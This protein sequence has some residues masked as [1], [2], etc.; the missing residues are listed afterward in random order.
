MYQSQV[1]R[2]AVLIFFFV[3]SLGYSDTVFYWPFDGTIGQELISTEDMFLGISLDKFTHPGTIADIR[4]G[5]PN[6]WFNTSGTSGEF[7]NDRFLNTESF[8]AGIV[9]QDL[10]VNTLLDLST[11]PSFT[12]EV[13]IYPYVVQKCTVLKKCGGDGQYSL[14]L[15]DEGDL[16]F[17]INRDQNAIYA[18]QQ[19]IKPYTWYHIAAVFD[20]HIQAPMKLFVNG[21]LV[22]WG[23]SSETLLDSTYALGVGTEVLQNSVPPTFH[24]TSMYFIGRIDDLR[25]SNLALSPSEFLIN[26]L[27]TKARYPH[28]ENEA[29]QFSSTTS[30]RWLPPEG[31]QH[32]KVYFGTTSELDSIH[33]LKEVGPEVR[34]ISHTE[35]NR[36]LLPGTTYYWRVDCEGDLDIHNNDSDTQYT[37]EQDGQGEVWKFTAQDST[38]QGYLKWLLHLGQTP[39]DRIEWV[40]P[41]DFGQFEERTGHVYAPEP[42]QIYDFQDLHTA[43]TKDMLIW[44]PEY[45]P[46]GFF[47]ENCLGEDYL[48]YYHIYIVSPDERQARFGLRSGSRLYVWNNRELLYNDGDSRHEAPLDFTLH[49]G[50][51]SITFILRGGDRWSTYLAAR[52][53][54]PNG[55]EYPDLSYSLSPPLP[56]QEIYVKRQLPYRYDPGATVSV[57]LNINVPLGTEPNE[58]RLFETIPKGFQVIDTGE[59]QVVDNTIQ[60]HLAGAEAKPRDIVYTLKVPYEYMNAIA[61]SGH[62]YWGRQ[63]TDI[64][65]SSRLFR[66]HPINP[67]DCAEDIETIEIDPGNYTGAENVAVEHMDEAPYFILTGLRADPN[68]GWASY[69]FTVETSSTYSIILDYA[70]YWTLFHHSVSISIEIDDAAPIEVDLYPTTHSYPNGYL[71]Q[72]RYSP[73]TDPHR[74]AKWEIGTIPLNAG[75]HTLRMTFPEFLLTEDKLDRTTDGRPVINRIILINYPGLTLPH[76]TDPHHLDSYEH[77]PA[78][79]VHSRD[80]RY[81]ADGRKEL[82]F[83]GTF[84]SLSQGDEIYASEIS[85]RPQPG[86][87][88]TLFETVSLEPDVFH[89]RS[90]GE[91]DFALTVR[92]KAPIPDDYSELVTLWLQGV[93]SSPSRRLYLFS[94][95]TEYLPLPPFSYY[96]DT[97]YPWLGQPIFGL[98]GESANYVKRD[99]SDSAEQF[100]P[101]KEDLGFNKGR[102]DRDIIRFF[103]DQFLTGDL[104]GIVQIFQDNFWDYDNHSWMNWSHFWSGVFTSLYKRDSPEQAKAYVKRLSDNL[105]FYPVTTRWDWTR[106]IKLPNV[107]CDMPGIA[108]LATHVRTV[109]EGI[110]NDQEQCY[111]LHNL[112]LPLFNSYIDSSRIWAVLADDVQPG[113]THIPILRSSYGPTGSPSDGFNILGYIMIGEDL[114]GLFCEW[115]PDGLRLNYPLE[116]AYAKGTRIVPFNFYEDV[117]LEARD[118]MS[119][120]ALGAASRDPVII[121]ETMK[122]MSLI[123]EKEKIFFADGSFRN[124][125]GSYGN[126]AINYLLTLS[127]AEY[128]FGQQALT[129]ISDNTMTR[130]HNWLLHVCNF[131]F[132]NQLLPHLNGGG[133]MNQLPRS[134]CSDKGLLYML[135]HV[136]HEDQETLDFFRRQFEQERNQQLGDRIDNRSFVVHDWGYAM[137]RSENRIW[138]RDMETLLSSK[139]LLSDPGDHVSRD[140]LGIVIYGLGA[141]LTP[142]YGYS[143]IGY[144]SPFLNQ[145]MIDNDRDNHYFGSFWH[146]DGRDELPCAVAHT[147]DGNDCSDLDFNMSRWCIQ[148]PEYLFDAYFV[149]AK[150]ANEHQYDWSLINMGEMEISEPDKL[151]WTP[152][153]LF[154]EGYWPQ[155]GER[156]AGE[157]NIARN[158]GGRIVADWHISNDLWIPDGD[159]RLLR[160]APQHSGRI[161]LIMAEQGSSEVINAQIGYDRHPD[162]E[163]TL[164]NS[165]D[166]LVVRQQAHSQSFIDTLEPIAEDEEAYV[167]NVRVIQNGPHLQRLVKI[168]T[169]EGEDWVYLSGQWGD[170]ANGDNP[171]APIKTDADIVAWRVIGGKVTRFYLAN[172]SYA[173]T[174]QGHWS[175]ESPGNH[176]WLNAQ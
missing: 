147:G 39:Q 21:R 23:G 40:Q 90:E 41:I 131:P 24:N 108:P 17:T 29:E 32:Q 124:E 5:R 101:D 12:L 26:A 150:D 74:R 35:L 154:L 153:P 119:L 175:F 149:E 162:G 43:S 151:A 165:Q 173:M 170:R 166:I 73:E 141:I 67:S 15:L 72:G 137:L 36:V 99:I 68:G 164:A 46:T 156:G 55:L 89:I 128:L 75:P 60:W 16:R 30:L 53:T 69:D 126:A 37:F 80:V 33:F 160:N 138:D 44:T 157:R 176:Y 95:A 92:S 31:V 22:G 93:A 97:D 64:I 2:I 107:W 34:N 61:F 79:L 70:E 135:E 38:P 71:D 10:G 85:V 28:P 58:L 148:F 77:A 142:R 62:A 57:R 133:C 134:Y 7:D 114:V 122:L 19:T 116:K 100:V 27:P 118:V 145:L 76:A 82:V 158:S 120:L 42:G 163:Q 168:T 11:L 117:E 106:P 78:R 47:G 50:T 94:T 13:F 51:N 172:G 112:V 127:K 169:A 109:Q 25:I 98:V 174:P 56:E 20:S 45:S 88:E 63:L 123:L 103:Q 102:Y 66:E 87:T 86:Q 115:G 130:L 144:H 1:F 9:A 143:W 83:Y 4:F 49:A 159:T 167:T 81:L 59:G 52:I 152:Y 105:A 48:Q 110:I 129:H 113:D 104:P 96:W 3:G 8:G 136:F 155:L 140:C 121:S 54:D 18:G 6:P 171:I 14:E 161:R 65:G 84:Y 91:Q 146:F 139:H 111:I 125:P 132:S